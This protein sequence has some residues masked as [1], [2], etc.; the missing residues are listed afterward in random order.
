MTRV[1]AKTL[2]QH[3]SKD[4][5]AEKSGFTSWTTKPCA[6]GCNGKAGTLN[7]LVP[8]PLSAV[9]TDRARSSCVV[10]D[11]RRKLLG[12]AARSLRAGV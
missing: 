2:S 4:L 10:T 11:E 6:S 3:K 8:R 9:T 5:T 12:T 7:P 1:R